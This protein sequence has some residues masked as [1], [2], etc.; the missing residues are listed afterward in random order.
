MTVDLGSFCIMAALLFSVYGAVA[1]LAGYAVRSRPLAASGSAAVGV[2]FGLVTLAM[3]ALVYAFVTRDFTLAFVAENSSRDLPLFYAVAAV[4][5]G[6]DGSLLLWEWILAVYAGLCVLVYRRRPDLPLPIIVFIM[7]VISTFLL[8]ILNFFQ[9]PF[10]LTPVAVTDGNG[11]NP[12]LQ[13]PGMIFHPPSLYLGYVGFAVPFAFAMAALVTGRLGSGWVVYTRRWTLAAWFFL[14]LGIV[15]GGQWAYVELGWGGYWAWDP[16]ENA[17]LMPWLVGTAFLHSVMVQQRGRGM[18]QTWNLSLI[19]ATFTLSLFGTFLTRS[20]LLSSVHAFAQSPWLGS[21]FLGFIALV[22]LAATGL[23]LSRSEELKC[24]HRIGS[25]LSRESA[26]LFNNLLLV[27]ATFTVFLGTLFPVISE[28]VRGVKVSVGMPYF[29]GVMVPIGLGLL[30]LMAVGPL[31]SWR[32]ASADNLRRN[33]TLPAAAA[34]V[35]AVLFVVIGMRGVYAVTAFALIIF[36]MTAAAV[37]LV[38]GVRA[39]MAVSG[40]GA[41]R[42]LGWLLSRRR[43]RYGGL[44]V[45]VGIAVMYLGITGSSAFN[46][47]RE[48]VLKPGEQFGLGPFRALYRDHEW[49]PERNHMTFRARFE[50][51]HDDGGSF[52]LAPEKRFYPRRKNPFS[53]AAIHADWRQDFYLVITDFARDGSLVTIKAFLNPLVMWL[54][55]GT[56]ILALG[57]L[58]CLTYRDRALREAAR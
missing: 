37:D 15:L 34:L 25:V 8:F 31:I 7:L 1:S 13:N 12:L 45:H 48:V 4:W 21:Y 40:A 38:R 9:D 32:A 56:G 22:A 24:N 6:Q 17:S 42:S 10:A 33:F 27:G 20:G 54:W 19:I 26:F 23:V 39:R 35:G 44:I 14:T 28:A 29:N 18:L 46:Q 30:F 57:A 2:V 41:L 49:K 11:M 58:M 43:R 55:I 36:F 52:V 47:Q 53:E 5:A 51:Y 50:V 16:V 3:A